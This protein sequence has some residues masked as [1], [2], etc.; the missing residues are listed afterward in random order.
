MIDYYPGG[1][2]RFLLKVIAA[3]MIVTF[4]WYD[5]AWAGDLFYFHPVPANSA[6]GRL[7]IEKSVQDVTNYDLLYYNKRKSAADKLLP[8]GKEKEQSQEFAPGYVQEQQEKHEDI[9]KQKQAS[10]DMMWQMQDALRKKLQKGGEEDWN[11]KKRRGGG[12][13]KRG[14]EGQALK[15]TLSDYDED[16]TPQTLNIYDYNPDGSLKSITSYD[17]TG[18]DKSRWIS[19]GQEIEDKEG[20]KFFGSFTGADKEGLTD[21]R[22]LEK[23]VYT[24]SKGEERIDYVLSDYDEEGSPTSV[25]M[26]D[27]NKDGNPENLDE[28]V[29]YD[30]EGLDID[31]SKSKDGWADLLTEDRVSKTAVYEGAKGEERVIYVLDDYF[32]GEDGVNR[33][34]EMSVY[35]YNNDDDEKNLDEVRTYDISELSNQDNWDEIRQDLLSDDEAILDTYKDRLL[36]ISEFSGEKGGERIEQTY[37]Y[38]D[39]IIVERKDYEY[40]EYEAKYSEHKGKKLTNIYTFDVSGMASEE[41]KK[42][43]SVIV[44]NDDG[45]IDF[46]NSELN[47][48]LVG[49][50]TFSGSGGHEQIQQSFVYEDQTIVERKDYEYENGILKNL[51]TIDVIG[52]GTEAEKRRKSSIVRNADG[53]IDYLASDLNGELAEE[54]VF[55]GAR[56]KERISETFSYQDGQIYE[57]KEYDY[58]GKRLVSIKEYHVSLLESEA[59]KRTRGEGEEAATSYLVGRAGH[60]QLVRITDAAGVSIFDLGDNAPID[61]REIEKYLDESDK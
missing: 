38:E 48:D 35:D 34:G 42:K 16:G 21:D 28:V 30:L 32:I 55:E 7:D 4:V 33:A 51:Y 45:T 3:I 12:G 36:T 37:Y 6:K 40:E 22:I 19:K 52:A 43:K 31:F 50:D 57:R 41:E 18:L 46:A 53:T 24:G 2:R 5:I 14:Q 47:G 15:Y 11:L 58:E 44:R 20:K 59:L 49:E 23:V 56:G 26:Y 60:E 27:Y 13:E 54:A 61:P 39:G 25:S 8:T 29:T 17:I 10:E 9:I 1:H